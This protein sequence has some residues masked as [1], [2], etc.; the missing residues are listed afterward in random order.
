MEAR[1]AYSVDLCNIC[2]IRHAE[3]GL[4]PESRKGRDY[5]S[6][7]II[8]EIKVQKGQSTCCKRPN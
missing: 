8:A 1:G 4:V 3:I 6:D 5:Q 2:A 7:F